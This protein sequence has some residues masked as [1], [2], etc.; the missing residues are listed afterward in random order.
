MSVY[1]NPT[2]LLKGVDF[3]KV[4]KD[5]NDGVYTRLE[6]KK[7]KLTLANNNILAD[8]Y[9]LSNDDRLF[10]VKDPFNNEIICT[11]S[12]YKDVEVFTSTGGCL[13]IG[14]RCEYCR[15]DYKTETIGIP[16]AYK[17]FSFLTN[18]EDNPSSDKLQSD[19]LQSDKLQ[20]DKLQSD[21]LQSDKLQSDKLQSDKL[22]SDDKIPKYKVYYTFWVDGRFCN[23]SCALSHINKLLSSHPKYIDVIYR[24][25]DKLLKFMYKCLYP[26]NPPIKPAQDPKLL[27]INGGSLEREEWENPKY[28][29]K[30]TNNIIMIPSKIEYIREK[31]LI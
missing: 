7:Q 10:S 14:G 24:D 28:V 2:F 26:N 13:S 17:E 3:Y 25:S 16:I 8:I 20:S 29:Y 23:F 11:T 15:D 27:M 19:K 4:L 1:V 18:K 9:S 5:Y 22:Q 31:F 30:K 21:K 12:G 6:S